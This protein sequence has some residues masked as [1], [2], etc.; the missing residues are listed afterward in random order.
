MFLFLFIYLFIYLFT[1]LF[2]YFWSYLFLHTQIPTAIA[3]TI[4]RQTGP[5]MATMGIA[6]DTGPCYLETLGKFVN[7]SPLVE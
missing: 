2:I 6:L 1:Y 7:V 4:T 3:T 5:A